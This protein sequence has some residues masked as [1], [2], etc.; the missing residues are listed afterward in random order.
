MDPILS[1]MQPVALRVAAACDGAAYDRNM[2]SFGSN[3]EASRT[4]GT[5]IAPAAAN[6]TAL[7]LPLPKLACDEND[8]PIT[9]VGRTPIRAGSAAVAAIGHTAVTID[10]IL[11]RISNDIGPK[12]DPSGSRQ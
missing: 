7:C 8:R 3:D 10:R 1:R 12:V 6:M 11:N 9:Y 5:F 2:S 4:C